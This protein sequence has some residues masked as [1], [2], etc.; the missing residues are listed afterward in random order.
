MSC[1]RREHGRWYSCGLA[2]I[3]ATD[4][5]P[6]TL[7]E[8]RLRRLAVGR[9]MAGEVVLATALVSWA[10]TLATAAERPTP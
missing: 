4:L 9:A 1:H 6:V 5:G 3:S 8:L 10:D 2:T 7:V